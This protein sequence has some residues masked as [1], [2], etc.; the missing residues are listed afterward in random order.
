MVLPTFVEPQI[1]VFC[2]QTKR[3][4]RHVKGPLMWQMRI[5]FKGTCPSRVACLNPSAA[6]RLGE[7]IWSKPQ[8]PKR[9]G[10]VV[11][12]LAQKKPLQRILTSLGSHNGSVLLSFALALPINRSLSP[13]AL[14][15][16]FLPLAISV[17][18]LTG[19][20]YAA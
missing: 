10:F 4:L 2:D 1:S 11:V 7:V 15:P 9:Q 13:P 3:R 19:A 18:S 5:G 6:A 20:T 8:A 12:L 17:A 14:H 16:F